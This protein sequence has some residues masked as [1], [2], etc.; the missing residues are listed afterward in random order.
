M[1]EQRFLPEGWAAL[2][3]EKKISYMDKVNSFKKA[4]ERNETLEGLVT[5][6]DAEYNL[7][8]DL[9]GIMGIVPRAEV[10][11][12]LGQDGLPLPV[13]SI[14]KDGYF[15]GIRNKERCNNN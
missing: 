12:V 11:S 1:T 9:G 14:T 4:K 13:A 15:N 8:V 5:M 3:A 2:E 6:A 10:S 7:H